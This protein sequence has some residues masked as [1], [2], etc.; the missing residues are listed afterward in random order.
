MRF[1]FLAPLALAAL[2]SAETQ[3]KE[4]G[5]DLTLV[6]VK[7]FPI[8]WFKIGSE[9]KRFG[10]LEFVGGLEMVSDTRDFGAFSAFRF[11]GAGARFLGVADTGFWFSGEVLRDSEG[12]PTG[13][14]GFKMRTMGGGD[15]GGDDTNGTR[16]RKAW[17]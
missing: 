8:E 14:D 16:T 3:S 12:R 15:G 5:G 6:S 10:R 17:C 13:L 9:Q 1:K 11:D 4:A 2:L 7:A